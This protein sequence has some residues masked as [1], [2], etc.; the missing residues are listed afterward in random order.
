[1]NADRTRKHAGGANSD[2][3]NADRKTRGTTATN[4]G[5]MGGHVAVAEVTTHS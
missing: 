5:G 2:S 3:M 4:K 1:M